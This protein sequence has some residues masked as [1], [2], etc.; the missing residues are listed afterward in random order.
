MRFFSAIVLALSI[1]VAATPV[2]QGIYS[3]FVQAGPLIIDMWPFR[4]RG[5]HP[6]VQTRHHRPRGLPTGLRL[7][8]MIKLA[9]SRIRQ[10]TNIHV[11]RTLE[12]R[13]TSL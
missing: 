13:L 3:R 6:P 12:R 11:R 8:S 10:R 2:P 5:Q 7:T 1:V 9:L 4:R